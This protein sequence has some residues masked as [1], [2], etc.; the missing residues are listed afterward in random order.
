MAET[1]EMID[2]FN[3]TAELLGEAVTAE[4]VDNFNITA[5]LEA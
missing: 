2:S 4:M 3:I 1:A 5:E